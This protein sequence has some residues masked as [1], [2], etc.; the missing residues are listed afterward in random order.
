MSAQPRILYSFSL[1]KAQHGIYT[2]SVG[3][4][5]LLSVYDKTGI[6]EFARILTELDFEIISTGGT[7]KTLKKAGIPAIAVEDV[8]GFSEC[9]GGR[10]K[11]MHPAVFGGILFRRGNPDDEASADKQKI[12]PIGLV[13]VNL[14]PFA[15]KQDIE[16]IDIGGPALLRSAAKNYEDVI[17]VCDP[18]DYKRVAAELKI[19]APSQRLRRELAAKAFLRTA[20]Y[21]TMIT[22]WLS[23]GKNTGVMLTDGQTLRYGENPHQWGKYFSIFEPSHPARTTVQPEEKGVCWQKLQGKEVSYLNLLDADAAWAAA[24]EFEA[25]TAVFVKHANPSGIASRESIEDAFQLA[26]DA[27]RLSAF[28]VIIALNRGCT[29]EI[30]QKIIEQKIFVEVIIA[31]SFE[32]GTLEILRQKPNIRVIVAYGGLLQNYRSA[33]GGMLVQNTD[34]RI[35]TERDLT[36]VTEKKPSADQVRDLLFAWKCVKHCKSNAIVF[37]KDRVTVGI[38]AGQTSRV[39]AAWIAAKRAGKKANGA[40]MASDAFFPFPDSVEEA[41]SRG[42]AAIIQPGGSVRDQE[43]FAKAGAL[44]VVM[45]TTGVRAFRH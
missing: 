45:V 34:D 4:R 7:L 35:V 25:P 15:D 14:Y 10:V 17:V 12:A 42:I 19:G 27:D 13:C 20:A 5:A 39:D 2:H 44:E 38:G 33:L 26:Y 8:T 18:A 41:A 36:V 11:T 29:A 16:T 28:G 22:E 6:E 37:A 23:D 32:N 31:P 30:A 43:I 24:N 21:D 9:F 40:V 3:K 1:A